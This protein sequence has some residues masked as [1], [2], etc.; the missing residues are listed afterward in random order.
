MRSRTCGSRSSFGRVQGIG[1]LTCGETSFER[2][3]CFFFGKKFLSAIRNLLLHFQLKMLEK[4]DLFFG[5]NL[6]FLE[7]AFFASKLFLL[8]TDRLSSQILGIEIF[9]AHN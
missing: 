7:T 4:Y 8:E 9:S 5:V 2:F 3:E 6:D 1:A